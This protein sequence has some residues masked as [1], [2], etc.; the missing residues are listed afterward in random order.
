MH[1]LDSNHILKAHQVMDLSYYKTH[2]TV[3]CTVKQ[4]QQQRTM[5]A[6]VIKTLKRQRKLYRGI[7]EV[8]KN[9]ACAR[10]GGD[11]FLWK[12]INTIRRAPCCPISTD[13]IFPASKQGAVQHLDVEA[14]LS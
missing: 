8:E 12:R 2:N 4:V 13:Q 6:K 11:E 9:A 10:G 7:R 3:K 5:S 14:P 1:S